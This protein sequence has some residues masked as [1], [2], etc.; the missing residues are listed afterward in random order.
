MSISRGNSRPTQTG[1]SASSSST[2]LPVAA[3]VKRSFVQDPTA[4]TAPDL[5]RVSAFGIP[6]LDLA[7]FDILCCPEQVIDLKLIRKHRVLPLFQRSNRL[8]LAICD[9]ADCSCLNDI[10]F[11][12][13]LL[14][15]VVLVAVEQLQ[16]AVTEFIARQETSQPLQ[17]DW[18]DSRLEALHLEQVLPVMAEDAAIDE[19][20][21]VRFV[22]NLLLDAIA[23]DASDIHIEPYERSYRVRFRVDG[24]LREITRPPIRLAGRIA[25]R[26]KV[27]AQLDISETRLPQD[28]RIKIRTSR[29]GAMDFRV[30]ILPTMWGEKIVLRLLDSAS[31]RIGIDALGFTPEQ[32]LLYLNALQRSQGLVMVTGPTGSGKSVTLYT[33]LNILNSSERNIATAEDP[34]EIN[35][36][37]LNQVSVNAK[38]GFNF[39]AALRA[40]LRQDPDVIMVGEI[41][42]LETADTALKAA[43]TGHLV[44]STLHTNTAVQTIT[45]LLDMGIAP[46][47]L[48]TSVSLIIAQRLA[49]RL[50][51][52]C[53][54]SVS[55]S[56]KVLSDA[57]FKP[58][59]VAGNRLF[60]AGACEKCRN[61]YKGRV[62]IFEVVPIAESLSQSNM[63]GATPIELAALARAAGYRNLRESA[64]AQVASGHTSLDEANRLV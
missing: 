11:H 52:H 43:Q 44:L 47:N 53:K 28:G 26:I 55:I 57:G 3:A 36:D 24:I 25:A 35:I 12:T 16:T 23:S 40:F 19:A 13:G 27:M 42:D 59:Q 14:L 56:E 18:Q 6:L 39:T 9:P 58:G 48:A 20:P 38:Q 32:K 62:G 41:R 30:N 50:C 21:I 22:N 46:F 7:V 2:T 60:R 54:E 29:L 63:A 8:F 17:Q 51:S 64:L 34:V 31:A 10:K 33:G 1:N 37:G 4:R 45:R 61:G 15:D 49:R 5:R